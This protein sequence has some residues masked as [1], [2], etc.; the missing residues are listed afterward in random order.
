[1][2]KKDGMS[3]RDFIKTSSVTAVGSTFF[4][5][6]AASLSYANGGVS[7]PDKNRTT[8]VLIRDQ[9]VLDQSGKPDYEVL[10]RMMD[11]AVSELTGR[12]DAIEGWKSL[13]KPSDRVGIK[14]NV[15]RFLPTPGELEQVLETR[16]KDAGVVKKNIQIQDRGLYRDPFFRNATALINTRPLRTHHWSGVGSLIKNYITFVD[17]PQDL[18]GDSCADLATVWKLPLVK[19]KTR[20]NVLV[21]LTP[22]FHGKGP[23]SFNPKYVWNYYGLAVGFDPVAVDTVG[24]EVLQKKRRDFFGE[25]RPLNPP[26]KHILLADSR[27]HL[28]V[29]DMNKINLVKIG[30]EK[31]ILI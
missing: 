8:V 10:L 15:W 23:H 3:R 7:A 28:G 12:K 16:V 30:Y 20:L 6:S 22:Q 31:D 2:K 25:E 4:L 27:H 1:M 19:D 29:A 13:V 14:T 9:K 24:L 17:R 11:Q 5:S 21:L 18:H 26:A